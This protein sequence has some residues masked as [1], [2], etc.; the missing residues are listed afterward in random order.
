MIQ[1]WLRACKYTRF[2]L[3]HPTRTF[4]ASRV[5]AGD[6]VGVINFLAV[7]NELFPPIAAH[8]HTH[9]LSQK[10]PNLRTSLEVRSLH[11]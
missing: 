6:E 5:H 4:A 10:E 1:S 7:I 2:C 8:T 3:H 11:I 9:N